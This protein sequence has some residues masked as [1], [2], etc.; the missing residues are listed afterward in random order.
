L[1]LHPD[2]AVEIRVDEE[3]RSA[4]LSL[5]GALGCDLEPGARVLV[6]RHPRPLK[7]VKLSG[8]AFIERLRAKLNL[9]D[10]T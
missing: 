3:G 10:Q 4:A 1:V 7:L 6:R 2:Q 9:P 8:P 5:D